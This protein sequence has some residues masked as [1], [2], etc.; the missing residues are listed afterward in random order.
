MVSTQHRRKKMTQNTTSITLNQTISS[1]S[2]TVKF[3][4]DKFYHAPQTQRKRTYDLAT[5]LADWEIESPLMVD[6]LKHISNTSEGQEKIADVRDAHGYL[7]LY[8]LR[9]KKGIEFDELVGGIRLHP[10][11]HI[12]AQALIE[13]WRLA[14]H[15]GRALDYI[16]QSLFEHGQ[17]H[18]DSL[19]KAEDILYDRLAMLKKKNT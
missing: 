13:D 18:C 6:V 17:K 3:F 16:Y 8:L 9:S 1:L 7:F 5:V 15:Q 12:S 10:K 19:K 11:P 4:K 14:Y 2:K